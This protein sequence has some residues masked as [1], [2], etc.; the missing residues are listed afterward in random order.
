M[1]QQSLV[2]S[3]IGSGVRQSSFKYGLT[4]QLSYD[5]YNILDLFKPQFPHLQNG[6]T[7]SIIPLRPFFLHIPLRNVTKHLG[8]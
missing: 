7:N 6:N 1:R 5:L 2:V 3:S 8:Q 4:I